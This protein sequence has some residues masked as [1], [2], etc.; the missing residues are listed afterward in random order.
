VHRTIRLYIET[1]W[2]SPMGGQHCQTYSDVWRVATEPGFAN[3][4]GGQ[5][6]DHQ[7]SHRSSHSLSDVRTERDNAALHAAEI[8]VA[9]HSAAEIE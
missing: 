5:E 7:K 8:A 2:L 4:L 3:V 6:H 1:K 9:S